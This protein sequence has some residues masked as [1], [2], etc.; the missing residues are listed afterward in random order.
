MVGGGGSSRER[1]IETERRGRYFLTVTRCQCFTLLT[2]KRIEFQDV[3]F[4][5]PSTYSHPLYLDYN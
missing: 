2:L 5:L 3:P 1:E 4:K